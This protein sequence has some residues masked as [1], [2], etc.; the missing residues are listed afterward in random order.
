MQ[1]RYPYQYLKDLSDKHAELWVRFAYGEEPWSRYNGTG[2]EVGNGEGVIMLADEREGWVEKSMSEYEKMSRV[3]WSTLEELLEA[4]AEKKGE[5]W[6][7]MNMV[8]LKQL[9]S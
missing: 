6:F 9:S 5:E 2:N 1:F 8:A 3:E 4:W 7:P